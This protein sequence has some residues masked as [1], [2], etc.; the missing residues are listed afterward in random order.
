MDKPNNSDAEE[1][2]R[3][4]LREGLLCGF[5]KQVEAYKLAARI[6]LRAEQEREKCLQTSA[7]S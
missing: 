1:L 6:I 4:V 7:K 5:N 3:T 2:A